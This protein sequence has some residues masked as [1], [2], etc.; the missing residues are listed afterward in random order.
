MRAIAAGESYYLCKCKN[1]L[2]TVNEM[3]IHLN[4]RQGLYGV[5][6]YSKRTITVCTRHEEFT[7][8][9]SDFKTFAGGRENWGIPKEELDEFLSVVRP[10]EYRK[11][12]EL[13]NKILSLAKKMDD[14]IESSIDTF[15]VE[16]TTE[17]HD[18]IFEYE[19]ENMCDYTEPTIE[20]Y[21]KLWKEAVAE[22]GEL[23][24]RMRT[25]AYQVYSQDLDFNNYQNHDGIKFIIQTNTDRSEFR[26]C[27]DPYGFVSNGHS[28]ISMI[29]GKD[30][31]NTLNGG[32]I[33]VIGDTVILYSKSGDY[34]VYDDGVAIDC[35]KKVFPTKEIHSYAGRQWDDE[36]D[37]H[38]L[39]GGY[40]F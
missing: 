1:D 25:I 12:V 4:S 35:A 17:D 18:D 24:D 27:W 15:V 20:E 39:Q 28:D 9:A 38:Y 5:K 29:F 11:Q 23:K 2:E 13:E 37:F 40:P 6:T 32:W 34:G 8:P 31:W 19:E 26:F 30:R 16:E 3:K 21:R 7:V 33:K 22:S 14:Q 10:E 36:L